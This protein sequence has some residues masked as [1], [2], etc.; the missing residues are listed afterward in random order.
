VAKS[1][2]SA[3]LQSLRTLFSVG[4]A[5]GLTDG[6]LLGLFATRGGEAAELAFAALVERHGSMVLRVCRAFTGD[7]HDAEDAFQA[8]FLI[9]A[10]RS[11]SIRKRE[12]AA[13]WLH[14]VARRVAAGARAAATRRRAHERRAAGMA[15]RWA[16]GPGCDDLAPVLHEEI[17]RLSGRH[18]AAIV[19]CDLEGLTE[20]QAAARLG[21]PVG[22]VRSRLARGRERLRSRLER[23]GLDPNASPLVIAL[24]PDAS[25]GLISQALVDA[26]TGAAIRFLTARAT[27]RGAAATLAQGVLR[28]MFLTACFRA[29]TVVLAVGATASGVLLLAQEKASHGPPQADA[30]PPATGAR[31]T[32]LHEAKPGKLTVTV[33][34]RGSLESSNALDVVSEVEGMT[35]IL[36]ILPEGTRVKKGDLVCE[37]DSA[38]LRDQLT[39]QRI[40]T[41]RAEADLEQARTTREV[42]ELA[43]KE[44]LEG[45]FPLEQQEL[46]GAIKVAEMELLT[47]QDELEAGPRS[48]RA[49]LNVM[50]A[51]LSLRQAQS[52]LRLL[53]Q[54]TRVRMGRTLETQIEKARSD[55]LA[56]EATYEL[57]KSKEENLRKQINKCKLFAP[58]DGLVVYADVPSRPGDSQPSRIEEGATVR[59]RQKIFSL[60]DFTKMRVN[61]KVHE[62]MV[63]RIRPGMKV[64]IQ[65][66]AFPQQ[67]LEGTVHSVNPLPDPTNFFQFDAKVYT[68]FVTIDDPHPGLRPGM[69][70]QVEILV[71]ELDNVLSVPIKAV[72]SFD[73]KDH[74]AVKKPDGGFDWREVTLGMTNDKLIEVKQ[75][76]Q[77][78]E[79]VSLDPLALMSE[80]E[81]REKLGDPSKNVTRPS[82]PK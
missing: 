14:G 72:L 49:E 34:E 38:S 21:L 30:N 3:A 56:K 16:E 37:L 76:L 69:S 6:E 10:E 50:K 36:H 39:N 57:E 70:A 81:K 9:L 5:G 43:L 32:P 54:F 33:S 28:T 60:P 26:T 65:V 2:G 24:R 45:T 40:A 46:E 77:G 55:E 1:Q 64:R 12:S 68:T 31:D 22:T 4:A 59:E 19:L 20:G 23:R 73:G 15:K 18:R 51:E 27:V 48:R 78:G 11:G 66:D 29:A 62:S 74:V 82:P 7:P 79:R 63:D 17:G 35:T 67:V 53:S 13:S 80:A 41:Q 42:A 44:Y 8:T 58:G 71:A 75:G 61:A 47:A 25:G 52:K